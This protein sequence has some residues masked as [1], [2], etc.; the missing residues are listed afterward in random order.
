MSLVNATT[1]P[2][3]LRLV[4]SGMLNI[5]SLV[6]HRMLTLATPNVARYCYIIFPVYVLMKIRLFPAP[7][8]LEPTIPLK[9]PPSIKRSKWLS[10]LIVRDLV[11][12]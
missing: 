7:M 11:F 8:L 5:G 12:T 2:R 1:N 4:E 6:T 3:L 9:R 10:T